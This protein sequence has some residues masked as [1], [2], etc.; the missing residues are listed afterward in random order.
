MLEKYKIK[1]ERCAIIWDSCL[2]GEDMI[3]R[4]YPR[5]IDKKIDRLTEAFNLTMQE[6]PRLRRGDELQNAT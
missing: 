1:L 5:V 3:M 6:V 2:I 4:Y